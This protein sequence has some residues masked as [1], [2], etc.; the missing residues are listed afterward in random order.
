MLARHVLRCAVTSRTLFG[1]GGALEAR[2]ENCASTQR[3]M[4]KIELP[5]EQPV[6]RLVLGNGVVHDSHESWL[7]RASFSGKCGAWGTS[8][9]RLLNKACKGLIET[10]VTELKRL[11]TGLEHQFYQGVCTLIPTRDFCVNSTPHL[12]RTTR[13]NFSRALLK[14]HFLCVL[15]PSSSHRLARMSCAALCLIRHSLHR[16]WALLPRPRYFFLRTGRPTG[17]LFG[18]FAEQSPLTFSEISRNIVILRESLVKKMGCTH[19]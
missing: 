4:S 14:L 6:E 9:P 17:L 7:L 10:R 2:E 19:N 15:S 12:A 18:R 1:H 13:A 16:R 11:W 3:Q 8:A 5:E